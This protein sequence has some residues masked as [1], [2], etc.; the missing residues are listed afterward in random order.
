MGRAASHGGSSGRAA[1]TDPGAVPVS[2][3][4]GRTLAGRYQLTGRP[5][6]AGVAAVDTRSG[7]AVR[8]DAVPLPE[9]VTPFDQDRRSVPEA[10]DT[11][12]RALA[13]AAFAA[14]AV[15]DHARLVQTF[16]AFAEDGYLWVAGEVVRGVPLELLLDRGGPL[17][18]YRAAEVAGD[19]AA[20]LRAVHAVGLVHGNVTL[21]TVVVCDDGSALLGGLAVGAAQ[22]ALCGGPGSEIPGAGVPASAW[23]PARVRARDARTVV[24]GQVPE[25]WAPEQRGPGPAPRPAE[26]APAPGLAVGPAADVWALGALLHRLLT[27]DPLPS[28]PS[29]GPGSPAPG[30]VRLTKGASA[31]DPLGPLA[32]LVGRLLADDPGARP[33]LAEVEEQVRQLLSRAPEPLGPGAP[34]GPAVLLPGPRRPALLGRVLGGGGPFAGPFPGSSGRSAELADRTGRLGADHAVAHHAAPHRPPSRR[35]P[36]WLGAV[37][38]GS[39][40]LTVISVLV[41]AALVAG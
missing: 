28:D 24:V 33:D 36:G 11:A 27:G 21:E 17:A 20:A 6:G 30:P 22:E 29:D 15:P 16:E 31:P 37:L 39:V 26:A 32:P 38:V 5:L 35:S 13:R 3:L 19:L 41:V 18:P 40:L 14:G 34:S 2:D 8:L 7:T 23:T 10:D 4:G 9:L 1:R 25:R 12:A